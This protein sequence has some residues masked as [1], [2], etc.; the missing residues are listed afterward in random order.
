MSE[1]SFIIVIGSSAGGLSAVTEVCSQLDPDI[2]AAVLI[3]MHLSGKGIGDYLAHRIQTST[4]LICQTPRQEMPI[5]KGHIYIAPPNEHLLLKRGQ[6]QLGHGPKENRWRPSIDVL[7]R[8]AAVNYTSR[9]IGTILTG[10]LH[11]G[12]SGMDAIKKCAGTTIVQDPNQAEYP[13]MPMSVLGQMEVDYCIPLEQFGNTIKAIMQKKPENKAPDPELVLEN[14]AS[15]RMATGPDN[16]EKIGD[17]SIFAC[18]DCGGNL[19]KISHGKMLKYRCHIGHSYS[20][21][22]LL[23]KQGE[24]VESSLW[25]AVRLMEERQYL[26]SKLADDSQKK[27][28]ARS[29]TE[30]ARK[31][32]EL[33]GYIND[34][35]EHLVALEKSNATDG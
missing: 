31:A 33:K 13:D 26:L 6:I 18:P 12:T 28:F 14:V 5:L 24:A 22:D 21:P 9:V 23:M 29:A 17:R 19:W 3:V 34:L 27:G 35:K 32:E 25:V 15:E 2:D 10:M 8:S 20:E 4:T 11:D 16:I 1:P 30:H 7:F